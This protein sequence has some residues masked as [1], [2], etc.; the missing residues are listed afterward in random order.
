MNLFRKQMICS[1]TLETVGQRLGVY[2]MWFDNLKMDTILWGLALWLWPTGQGICHSSC[3]IYLCQDRL[4]NS[5]LSADY[6]PAIITH[7]CFLFPPLGVKGKPK[8]YS[9]RHFSSTTKLS[10]TNNLIWRVRASKREKLRFVGIF[11]C[12]R[13]SFICV[14]AF[15]AHTVSLLNGSTHIS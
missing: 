1:F 3:V 9:T 5:T 14:N 10:Q 4:Y 6:L 8:C 2:N 7:F 12:W 15:T 11:L 13:Q